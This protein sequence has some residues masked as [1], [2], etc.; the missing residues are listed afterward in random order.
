M[1]NEIAVTSKSSPN[2]SGTVSSWGSRKRLIIDSATAPRITPAMLP[3]P[4]RMIMQRMKTE[5]PNSNWSTLIV[6]WKTPRNT[7]AKPPIDAPIAY[8]HSFD[9]H[10]VDAHRRGRHLVLADRDPRAAEARVAQADV[11]EQHPQQ[12]RERDEVEGR[13]VDAGDVV[14]ARDRRPRLVHR[15]DA[16][17]AVGDVE[18]PR[19]LRELEHARDDLAE[20]ER[21]DRQVVAAQAQRR[22]AQDRSPHRGERR[23][24]EDHEEEVDVDARQALGDVGDDD[25][26]VLRVEEAR[27]QPAR[28]ERADREERDVAE[29]EQA[30]EADDDVEAQGHHHVRQRL[31]DRLVEASRRTCRR[32]ARRGSRRPARRPPTPT[33][34]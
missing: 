20:R 34:A 5:K 32:R 9:A 10:E 1:P 14:E 16:L 28:H 31:D 15:G 29:V 13:D 7:P 4:P 6:F 2:F 30:R 19:S 27:H 18:P 23:R 12:H 26:D 21:D 22:R 17:A 11:D 8:A 3:M 33:S 24:D 25:V